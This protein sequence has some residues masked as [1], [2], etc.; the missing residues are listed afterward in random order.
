M[1]GLPGHSPGID[2]IEYLVIDDGS[3]DGTIDAARDCGVHHVLRNRRNM[4]LARSFRH[5]IDF[6]LGANADIIVNTDG[7]NQ[8]YGADIAKLVEPIVAGRA[9]VVIGDRR[10]QAISHFSPAK[11]FL[12]RFGSWAVRHFSAVD[13][14]DAVS[15]FRALS[16]AAALQMNI[17]S[18]SE[19]HTSELQS[20]MRISYAVFCLKKKKTNNKQKNIQQ[21]TPLTT[22]TLSKKSQLPI[23]DHHSIIC[24]I[25]HAFDLTTRQTIHTVSIH[26]TLYIQHLCVITILRHIK[27]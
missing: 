10:T 18:R 17:V 4:G 7:D 24:L 11:R 14:P 20:L 5:G 1:A 8:Y 15:G 16:R 3:T 6:A 26:T 21:E 19:E 12:Q 13:V 27:I 22:M 23:C 2:I 25:I 9:D